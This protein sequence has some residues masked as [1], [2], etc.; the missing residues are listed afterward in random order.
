MMK[1]LFKFNFE[2]VDTDFLDVCFITAGLSN[3]ES[4]LRRQS[5]VDC[6][7]ILKS[8]SVSQIHGCLNKFCCFFELTWYKKSQ[9]VL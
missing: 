8:D 7:C 1:M 2:R 9:L 3:Q 4:I 6:V 5:A